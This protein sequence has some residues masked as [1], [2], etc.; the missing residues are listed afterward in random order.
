MPEPNF[1]SRYATP[2][3]SAYFAD[4]G[5]HATAAPYELRSLPEPKST[6]TVKPRFVNAFYSTGAP[7]ICARA[8]ETAVSENAMIVPATDSERFV[9]TR[10][11]QKK[12]GPSCP[13]PRALNAMSVRN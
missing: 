7:S 12:R 9:S 13:G 6:P 1:G 4:M 8:I 3:E 2:P 11:L 5:A 10:N